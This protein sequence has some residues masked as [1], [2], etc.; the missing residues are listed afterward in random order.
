VD[1]WLTISDI[2]VVFCLVHLILSLRIAFE[3]YQSLCVIAR[4]EEIWRA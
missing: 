2:K 1:V 4:F 3:T